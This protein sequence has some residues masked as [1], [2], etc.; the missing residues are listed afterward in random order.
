[1]I[2]TEQQYR[3]ITGDKNSYSGDVLEAL[4]DAQN[5]VE[6]KTNRFYEL[7]ERTE[8]LSRYSDGKV[9]PSATPVVS[10]S[11]PVGA[12][13]EGNSV[14]STEWYYGDV[15]VNWFIS[16]SRNGYPLVELTYTGGW[17]AGS[18]PVAI[19]KVTAE[20]AK[21]ALTPSSDLPQGAT[22]VTVGDVTVTGNNL[23]NISTL[24]S[25]IN[26]VLRGWYRRSI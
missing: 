13:I 26:R 6:E 24:P 9:Y 20:I 16:D 8:K 4:A 5:T 3:K 19:V 1:M 18:I 21:L 17:A 14:S 10:V 7:A 11:S 22:S 12:A 25:S 23:G 2:C 15:A